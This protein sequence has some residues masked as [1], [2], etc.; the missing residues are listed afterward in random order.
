MS[1]LKPHQ[2]EDKVI[3]GLTLTDKEHLSRC[4]HCSTLYESILHEHQEWNSRLYSARVSEDFTTHIMNA[5]EDVE[6]EPIDPNEEKRMTLLRQRN[7]KRWISAAAVVIVLGEL[8][9]ALQQ[10]FVQQQLGIQEQIEPWATPM[11]LIGYGIFKST[12]N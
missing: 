11:E 9:Y 6:I 12:V 3:R 10:P 5:L 7:I 2:M 4:E 8:Y 1:C